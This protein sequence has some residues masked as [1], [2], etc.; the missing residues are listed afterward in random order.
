MIKI[1]YN[2]NILD[3]FNLKKKWKIMKI[4][5]GIWKILIWKL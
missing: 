2:F 4:K 1:I 5:M 3:Y